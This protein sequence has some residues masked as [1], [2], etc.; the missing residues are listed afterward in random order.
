MDIFMLI[1]KIF[2]GI[3]FCFAGIMHII[4]P[5][6]FKHFIPDF[7]PKRLVNYVA[8]VIEFVLGLGLFFPSTV[9]NATIGIFILMILFLPIHIWDV[10]KERPAIGSKKIA[11]IRIPLQFLLMYLLYLIYLNS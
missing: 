3:L 5:N 10:T 4:K 9:K 8:G 7:L 11:I 6:I 1:L 2:F